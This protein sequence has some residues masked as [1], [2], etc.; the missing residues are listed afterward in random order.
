MEKIRFFLIF[1]IFYFVQEVPSRLEIS[2][3]LTRNSQG[4]AVR[5][6]KNWSNEADLSYLSEG[7]KEES[8]AIDGNGYYLGRIENRK[9]I[10]PTK[11]GEWTAAF[12]ESTW[13]LVMLEGNGSQ[14]MKV[15]FTVDKGNIKTGDRL[16]F[17]SESSESFYV[18]KII[19][20]DNN[21][22][23][24]ASPLG[25]TSSGQIDIISKEKHFK[26]IK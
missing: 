16:L 24:W 13:E 18:A 26:N 5:D 2:P 17:F 23:I 11:E 1:L 9:L 19:L 6:L 14:K 8:I 20:D 21:L 10:F 22:D 3:A 4:L 25:N 15:W 12:L 7:M